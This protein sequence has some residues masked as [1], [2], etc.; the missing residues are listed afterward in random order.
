MP[1]DLLE[2]LSFTH[3]LLALRT[4][5]EILVISYLVYELI[6]SVRGSRAAPAVLGV[7]FVFLTYQLAEWLGL[8]AVRW[9]I[10]SAAPYA[11][12]ALVVIF[13]TEIRRAL[14]N[15]ALRIM[16]AKRTRR[17]PHYE[18]EDVVFA[19]G[20]LSHQKVGALI[21]IERET[22]LQTFIQSG[23]ALDA[24]LSNDLLSS[25]FQRQSPLHDGAVILQ[26]GRVAA[27]ACF[28]PLTTN[29]GLIS[30]L[31]TRHRAAIGI[32]EESDCL[33]LVVSEADGRVSVAS[34]GSIELGISDDRLRM[35]MIQYFGE[36]VSPPAT[37]TVAGEEQ[38]AIPA[39]DTAAGLPAKSAETAAGQN[40]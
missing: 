14:R 3:P 23:V 35:R 19:V 20:Q 7:V 21:V 10:G 30:T 16:P 9:L 33:A 12:V 31:G 6:Q 1:P 5:A 34:S 2:S 37:R 28:L 38:I 15:M 24:R 4:I 40:I 32:T 18:Y 29:P 8:D 36:V 27:A 22:G 26:R 13:Q 39:E 17:V 25:I 11:F